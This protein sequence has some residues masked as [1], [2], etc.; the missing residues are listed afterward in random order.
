MDTY[1]Q[2]ALGSRVDDLPAGELWAT[3][4]DTSFIWW[5]LFLTLCLCLTPAIPPARRR[6]WRWLPLVTAVTDDRL[7]G[8]RRW[9]GRPSWLRRTRT[10]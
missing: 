5:F 7:P 1:T 4:G 8:R 10:W 3:L 6:G 2:V 9:S